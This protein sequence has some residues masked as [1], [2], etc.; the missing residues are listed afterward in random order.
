[1][2]FTSCDR[3]GPP[4]QIVWV[5][6]GNLSNRALHALISATWPKAVE[7]LRAGED[8]VKLGERRS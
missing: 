5:T 7:L 6:T 4:P 1:M 8:L 2:P 3:R